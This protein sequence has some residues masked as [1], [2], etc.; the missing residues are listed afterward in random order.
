[1]KCHDVESL[2]T[3]E[4]ETRRPNLAALDRHFRACATCRR[5]HLDV[6]GV[7]GAG[8]GVSRLR[9]RS[10]RGVAVA[11]AAFLVMALGLRGSTSDDGSTLRHTPTPTSRAL[12]AS[13]VEPGIGRHAGRHAD[14][15]SA[16]EWTIND[17]GRAVRVEVVERIEREEPEAFRH[18]GT[19]RKEP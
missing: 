7:L 6:F 5:A 4:D 18:F 14:S 17:H 16:V 9:L 12:V 8:G 19:W 1:M 15:T 2:L 11:A 10:R 13:G 3:F